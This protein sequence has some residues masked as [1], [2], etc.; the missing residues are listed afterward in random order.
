MVGFVSRAEQEDQRGAP[1]ARRQAASRQEQCPARSPP[2]NA[3][4]GA[5]AHAR[6]RRASW[7]VQVRCRVHATGPPAWQA[8]Q[9]DVAASATRRAAHWRPIRRGT[10]GKPSSRRAGRLHPA[11][12][13]HPHQRDSKQPPAS[14]PGARGECGSHV[15]QRTN[16]PQ[17]AAR[18]PSSPPR[19][20]A[21]AT[22]REGRQRGVPAWAND[23]GSGWH[24]SAM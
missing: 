22:R 13:S 5:D 19:A 10:A 18:G 16:A 14:Q 3:G 1:G 12:G 20:R 2:R 24:C 11:P 23:A 17:D 6:A 7:G 8:G 15:R 21:A 4:Q 9:C